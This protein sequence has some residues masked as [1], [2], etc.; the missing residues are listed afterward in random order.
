MR[1]VAHGKNAFLRLAAR[2][3][4][5]LAGEQEKGDLCEEMIDT[6]FVGDQINDDTL[7]W[8]EDFELGRLT[9]PILQAMQS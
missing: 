7:D 4:A 1:V 8:R 3:M 6:M 5:H 9:Y 2:A